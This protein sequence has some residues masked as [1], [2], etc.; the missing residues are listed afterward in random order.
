MSDLPIHLYQNTIISAQ[1]M[2][3]TVTSDSTNINTA[4]SVCIQAIWSAGSTPVGTMVLQASNDNSTWTEVTGSSLAVSGA[5]GSNMWNVEKPAY[6]YIRMVYTR[7]S[8][9]GTLNATINAKRS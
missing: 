4:I 2:G 1:S 7:S 9:S 6:G 5:T 3:G 8:G